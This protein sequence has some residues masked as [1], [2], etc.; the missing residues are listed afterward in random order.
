M[1][2]GFGVPRRWTRPSPTLVTEEEKERE[3]KKRKNGPHGLVRVGR[4]TRD[5]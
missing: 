3:K 1:E 5:G 4:Q 2:R